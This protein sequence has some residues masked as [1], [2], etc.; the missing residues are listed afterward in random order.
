M[1][2]DLQQALQGAAIQQ[3]LLTNAARVT[4]AVADL[5]AALLD[6]RQVLPVEQHQQWSRNVVALADE[7]GRLVLTAADETPTEASAPLYVGQYL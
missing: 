2:I 6:A 1:A 7:T 5:R 3:R 4:A